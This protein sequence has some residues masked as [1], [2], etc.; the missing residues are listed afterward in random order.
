MPQLLSI[1]PIPDRDDPHKYV[2][3]FMMEDGERRTTRF[4]AK[5]YDDYLTHK[6]KERRDNYRAR[7]KKDLETND[8]TKAG[9]LSMYILWGDSTNFR[10]NVYKHHSR[11]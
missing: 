6:D 1:K 2:A 3:T 9:Y 11:L 8:P 10:E 4:G 7:H 5:G